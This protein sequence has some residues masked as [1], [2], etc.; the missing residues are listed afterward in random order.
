MNVYPAA[1]LVNYVRESTPI[2][3]IDPNQ[4]TVAGYSGIHMIQ[5]GAGE[6][7]D[8]LIKLLENV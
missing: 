6:G 8:E 1:G 7:V 2:Y 4:V 3:L 5:K